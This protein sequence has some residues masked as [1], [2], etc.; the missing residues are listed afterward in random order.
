MIA[1]IRMYYTLRPFVFGIEIR[2]EGDVIVSLG[3]LN[4]LRYDIFIK[5]NVKK[6]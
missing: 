6:K 4:L 3:V 2:D 5:A 1:Q